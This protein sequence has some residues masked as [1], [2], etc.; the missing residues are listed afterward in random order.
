MG[1]ADF[2]SFLKVDLVTV[3]KTIEP[4]SELEPEM[5]GY[6]TT[7]DGVKIRYGKW[8]AAT[9]PVKG[10]VLILQGRTEYIEKYLETVGDIR[11]KGFE[12]VVFDWRGQGGSDRMLEDPR[13]GYIDEYDEYVLDLE[14]IIAD[15]ALP[16]CKSP[17]YILGHSTGALV[18]LLAAPA[19]PNKIRRM[20]LCSPLL[21]IGKQPVSQ[22]AIRVL[23][24]T[25]TALGL[26]DSYLGGGGTPLISKPF[27][28]NPLTSDLARYERGKRFSEDHRE[29]TIGAPTA[30]WVFA[31][32]KAMEKVLD[33]DFYAEITIPA[34]F[35]LAGND[36][37]VDNVVAERLAARLRAGS[38]LTIDGAKH[39]L[40]HETDF[41]REQMLAAFFAF[42][43]GSDKS[44]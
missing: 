8:K 11:R 38:L 19:I 3:I 17:F 23:S 10:T 20:V 21:G 39:E 14:T 1:I 33:P 34:L 44:S 37:V 43:P 35:V 40:L 18:A 13:K 26:A 41:F 24:G 12:V 28:G 25:M 36:E 32:C 27:I 29:L 42:V 22:G 30:A 7:S 5:Q 15:V 6:V 2:K 9:S 4:G 31:S 16:D